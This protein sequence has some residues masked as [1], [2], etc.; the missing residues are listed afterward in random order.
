[1]DVR[2]VWSFAGQ[3]FETGDCFLQVHRLE[4]SYV[5]SFHLLTS[6]RWSLTNSLIRLKVT[7]GLSGAYLHASS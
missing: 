1:M 3:G 4:R 7:I 6:I 5:T 2:F